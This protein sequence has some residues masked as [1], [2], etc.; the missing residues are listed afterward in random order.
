MQDQLCLNIGTDPPNIVTAGI[1]I[2]KACVTDNEN[3]KKHCVVNPPTW[4]RLQGYSCECL[5][6]V[7]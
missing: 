4:R 7:F 2:P 5:L 3:W 1:E 6:T